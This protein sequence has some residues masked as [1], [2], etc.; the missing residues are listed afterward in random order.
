[1]CPPPS[2]HLIVIQRGWARL[3]L[4]CNLMQPF[5]HFVGDKHLLN[6]PP[7]FKG[8]SIPWTADPGITW[9]S[10]ASARSGFCEP[11]TAVRALGFPRVPTRRT[12]SEFWK[13]ARQQPK[14]VV[15]AEQSAPASDQASTPAH[16]ASLLRLAFFE[17]C[18]WWTVECFYL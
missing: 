3:A 16:P 13:T 7:C 5:L 10:S 2:C 6:V 8:S 14:W 17:A 11:S 1:M 15:M 4:F 18:R 9:V 12:R